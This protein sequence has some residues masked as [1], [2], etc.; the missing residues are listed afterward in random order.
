V[1]IEIRTVAPAR[2]REWID[3]IESAS[4]DRV[5]D[6]AWPYVERCTEIDRVLGAY[7]GD[8]LVGGGAAFSYQLTVPGGHVAAAGVTAVGV[9]PTHR[10]RGT[11]RQLM[12][13]QLA[14]VRTRGEAVAMLWASEGSIYGR[15][16]YGLATLNGRIEI[17]RERATFASPATPRGSFRLIDRDEALELYPQV[18]DPICAATPGF[19]GRNR[20]WWENDV[21]P[22]LQ[23]YRRGAGNKFYVVQE[24]DGHAV[25]YVLY[26]VISEWGDVGSLSV[27]QVQEL[28]ALDADALRDTWQFV[29]GVDLIHRI[30]AR[31]GPVDHPLLLMVSDPRRLALR[32]VDGLWLRIVDVEAALAARTYNGSGS[33]VLEVADGFMP[34]LAGRW[35]LHVESGSAT[36]TLTEDGPDLALDV[37]DLGAIYLGAFS[38]AQLARAGRTREL[39]PGARAAADALFTTP[40][41]PWC[42][43]V[44]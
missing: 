7:D 30:R 9:M 35:R 14:D 6:E 39:T 37:A 23:S 22:D 13:A 26:R 2:L 8:R 1:T 41:R 20:T 5:T 44:F 38:F 32:V 27:L 31:V 3:A 24:R 25:A 18:Y 16:G 43:Q 4:G 21:L 19:F 28:M 15:F 17:E 10:R 36:V 29:F 12:A 33:I 34:E 11:L 42:P 40:T